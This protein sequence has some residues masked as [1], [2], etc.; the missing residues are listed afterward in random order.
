MTPTYSRGHFTRGRLVTFVLA[1]ASEGATVGA[2]ALTVAFTTL[3]LF[4]LILLDEGGE[5]A[6]LATTDGQAITVRVGECRVRDNLAGEV[7]GL[8]GRFHLLDVDRIHE[9]ALFAIIDSSVQVGVPIP[10]VRL[11]DQA[12]EKHQV[13]LHVTEQQRTVEGGELLGLVEDGAL[14]AEHLGGT[15]DPSLRGLATA[16]PVEGLGVGDGPRS[17]L[18]LVA[19]LLAGHGYGPL[20]W[21]ASVGEFLTDHGYII[22]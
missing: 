3:G 10:E 9:G 12:A 15:R 16:A 21:G 2:V 8:L 6:V 4:L 19:G 14:D 22:A 11:V 17:A 20:M 1:S 7:E 5:E 18:L 13:C